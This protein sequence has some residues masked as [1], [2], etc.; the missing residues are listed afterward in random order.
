[1]W[2]KQ[3]MN[4]EFWW[5][6]VFESDKNEKKKGRR[7]TLRC[8]FNIPEVTFNIW[9]QFP[10]SSV[11]RSAMPFENGHNF[12]LNFFRLRARSRGEML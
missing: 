8:L 12:E 9:R 4:T 1:V 2:E 6:K 7:I 10:P 5:G 11:R 3:E